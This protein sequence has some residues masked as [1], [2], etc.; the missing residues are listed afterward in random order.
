MQCLNQGD[1]TNLLR[2]ANGIITE[3]KHGQNV[4]KDYNRCIVEFQGEIN[5]KDTTMQA[6]H[7]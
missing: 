7:P 5:F 1:P 2:T 4:S 6:Y 3:R